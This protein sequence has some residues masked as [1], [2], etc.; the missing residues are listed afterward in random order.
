[1]GRSSGKEG[2]KPSGGQEEAGEKGEGGEGAEGAT[3]AIFT[4]HGGD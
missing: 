4:D 2:E 3:A 1:M